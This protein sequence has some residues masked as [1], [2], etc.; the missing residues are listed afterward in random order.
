MLFSIQANN[1]RP[2][3]LQILQQMKF[4]MAAGVLQPDSLVPS[5]RDLARQLVVNPNTVARAYRELQGD[6]LLQTVRGTG[7]QI[8]PEAPDRCRQER[9][10]IVRDR[11]RAALEEARHSGLAPS[12]VE[13]IVQQELQKVNGKPARGEAP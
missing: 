8:T 7:L 6:G 9:G 2:I 5:V 10:R 3:Y 4:A 12:E 1:D 13:Q 11:L